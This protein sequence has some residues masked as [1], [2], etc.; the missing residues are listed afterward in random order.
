MRRRALSRTFFAASRSAW[1]NGRKPSR[2]NRPVPCCWRRQS[3]PHSRH[4]REVSSAET[5]ITFAVEV[6]VQAGEPPEAPGIDAGVKDRAILSTGATAPAVHVDRRPL[7]RAQRAVSQAS[8]GSASSRKKVSALRRQW[9][10]TRMW[11]RN[12]LR[13]TSAD[14][15]KRH[16]RTAIEALLVSN[17]LRNPNL[18]RPIAERQWGRLAEQQ[19]CKSDS[20]SG[21][22]SGSLPGTQARAAMPAGTGSPCRRVRTSLTSVISAW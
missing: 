6:G 22:W 1:L 17:T 4:F 3:P 7:K 5:T 11:E 21:M 20:A 13:S 9:E 12:A 8:K 18:T 16:S 10:R 2:R 19:A 15:V 14:F